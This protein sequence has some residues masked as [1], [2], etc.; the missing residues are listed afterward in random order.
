MARLW[1]GIFYCFW[2][3]DKPRVQQALAQEMADIVLSIEQSKD[4]ESDGAMRF[5]EGF[6][7][8]MVREWW[9]LDKWRVDKFMMLVRRFV[10]AGMRL[11][12]QRSWQADSVQRF[13][14]V[15]MKAGG[16]LDANNVKTPHGLLYHV[17][18]VYLE[19]LDKAC[20]GLEE[21]ETAL[22]VA[23]LI[24]PYIVLA[25]T[26]H[27]RLHYD[28]IFKSVLAPLLDDCLVAE[29]GLTRSKD[30]QEAFSRCHF[31]SVFKHAAQSP[32]D[33]RKQVYAALF[34]E[35]S[36]STSAE[37]R[38]RQIYKLFRDEQ[39]RLDVD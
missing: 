25:A 19:E 30:K 12:A 4:E 21:E 13:T 35:A 14:S 38:R 15:L 31:P 26:C 32:T 22:P 27:A 36:Q 18:D 17:C 29:K 1:K 20:Q 33:V 24:Q 7:D 37:A 11:L 3:S 6:F 10:G 5:L 39:D 34:K 2:M 9:G 16:V 28:R 8:A 23:A